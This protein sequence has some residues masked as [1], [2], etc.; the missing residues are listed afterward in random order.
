M[1]T[2]RP[3]CS[4]LRP[5]ARKELGIV[6]DFI[7]N[8][9]DDGEFEV[10]VEACG[11]RRKEGALYAKMGGLNPSKMAERLSASVNGSLGA[12][13]DGVRETMRSYVE[14]IIRKNAPEVTEEQMGLLLEHYLPSADATRNS[15]RPDLPPDALIG[16][17][18]DFVDFSEGRMPPSKQQ[19][20]WE[21]MPAWQEAYWRLFPPGLAAFVKAYLEKRMDAETFWSAAYSVLGL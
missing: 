16:M 13:L 14:G 2:S 18:R 3:F 10:I 17:V 5:M 11:R 21:S 1:V 9:A 19:E 6:L 15:E 4:M 7:L 12:T 20:L 8:H